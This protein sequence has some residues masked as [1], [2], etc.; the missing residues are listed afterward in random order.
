MKRT[1]L[2]VTI[3]DTHGS[4]GNDLSSITLSTNDEGMKLSPIDVARIRIFRKRLAKRL[5]KP[6]TRKV[7][8]M[9]HS[10]GYDDCLLCLDSGATNTLLK[11]L[12]LFVIFYVKLL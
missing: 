1:P 5:S 11:N 4:H 2:T 6:Y 8:N 12:V 9:H 7:Q 3:E 10:H